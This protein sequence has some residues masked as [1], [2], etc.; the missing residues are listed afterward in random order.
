[1]PI[2]SSQPPTVALACPDCRSAVH[3]E[4]LRCDGCGRVFEHENG[5]PVLL[6]SH[7][8][9]DT[10]QRQHALYDAVAHEYDDVFPRHVAEHYLNKRTGLIKELLPLGGLV[11]TRR[12]R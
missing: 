12:I 1:M 11:L 7:M 4:P 10:E 5:I 8:L 2:V 9:G 6:P 3:G